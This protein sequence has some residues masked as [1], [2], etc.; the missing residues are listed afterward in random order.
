MIWR[1][2]F[3]G[4][5]YLSKLRFNALLSVSKASVVFSLII[6]LLQMSMTFTERFPFDD[7]FK[8]ERA[9]ALTDPKR[10]HNLFGLFTILFA[11]VRLFI[12]GV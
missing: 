11:S 4:V 6:S 8:V 9:M 7:H 5:I 3:S 10:T 1:V 2:S 12:S